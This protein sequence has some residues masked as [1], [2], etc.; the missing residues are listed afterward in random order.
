MK[1]TRKT[2]RLFALGISIAALPS[3]SEKEKLSELPKGGGLE[4][5]K[6]L[7]QN[8]NNII[9]GA[10]L[11]NGDPGYGSAVALVGPGSLCSGTLVANNLVV[12]AAHCVRSGNM[13]EVFFGNDVHRKDGESRKVIG[14]QA[15]PGDLDDFPNHDLGWIK[16]EGTPPRGYKPEKI[17]SDSKKLAKGMKIMLVGFGTTAEG[18]Q[19]GISGR[20]L[21]VESVF[22]RYINDDSFKSIMTF[23]PVSG[24]GACHGDSGGPAYVKIDGEWFLFGATN[25][26]SRQLTPT[27]NCHAGH[28]I[29]TFVGDYLPWISTSSGITL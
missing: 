21:R 16:F 28:S 23:G 7:P 5:A 6:A 20:R 2:S 24:S 18:H 10:S 27:M 13:R 19:T 9:G 26:V 22:E 15:V 25:G 3:C 11:G 12:T 8:G 29:Y 17:L 14:Y 4:Q 1:K